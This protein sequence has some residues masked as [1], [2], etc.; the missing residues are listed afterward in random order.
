MLFSIFQWISAGTLQGNI[1]SNTPAYQHQIINA[2]NQLD[3]NC[4]LTTCMHQIF[5]ELAPESQIIGINK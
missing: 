3:S 5:P 2:C 4:L 1:S